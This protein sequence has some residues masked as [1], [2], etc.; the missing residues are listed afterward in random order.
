LSGFLGRRG[1][2]GLVCSEN[3][4]NVRCRHRGV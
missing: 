4:G 2:H 1:G 3:V